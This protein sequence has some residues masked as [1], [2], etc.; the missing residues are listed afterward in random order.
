MED[1]TPTG[2]TKRTNCHRRKTRCDIVDKGAP[3]TNCSK[4]SRPGCRLYEKKTRSYH[5]DVQPR[6]NRAIRPRDIN[7]VAA[8]ASGTPTRSPT[9]VAREASDPG[10][11]AEFIDRE[12][13]RT[14]AINLRG[15]MCFI[16]TG[17]SNFNYLVRQSSL[18]PIDEGAVHFANRQ[19]HPV[20]TAHDLRSVPPSALERLD[21][22]LERRLL[23]AYFERVNRGWPIVDEH[24]FMTQYES[25]DPEDGPSLP[26]LNAILIVGAHALGSEDE[27]LKA[28]QPVLFRRTK[29]LI[30]RRFDQDRTVYVQAALL[31]TWYSDGLE[32]LT[33]NAWH[34]IGIATRIALGHGIHRDVTKSRMLPVSKRIWTR[35]WWVLVQFDTMVSASYGRI[36]ALDID[37][38]DVPELERSHFEGIPDADAD[39]VIQHSKLCC[40][41]SRTMRRRWSLRST[42]QSQVKATREAD[43]ALALFVSQLPP[44]LHLSRPDMNAWKATLHLTY[45]NFLILLHRPAPRNNPT[46]VVSDAVSNVCSDL[47]VCGVAVVAMASIFDTLRHRGLL[48][49]LWLYDIHALFTA[50]IHVSCELKL[51]NPLVSARAQQTFESLMASLVVLARHWRFAQGLLC[52]FQQRVQ[53]SAPRRALMTATWRQPSAESARNDVQNV[54]LSLTPSDIPALQSAKGKVSGG[55]IMQVTG[56]HAHDQ[57][58]RHGDVNGT[59]A[60]SSWTVGDDGYIGRGVDFPTRTDENSNKASRDYLGYPHGAQYADGDGFLAELPSPDG[61]AL[62]FLLGDLGGSDQWF[63]L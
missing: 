20:H 12:E 21:T 8:G 42:V 36:P 63:G 46:N 33:A 11:L 55:N 58:V 56:I 32:E 45:N 7:P 2:R 5:R 47:S 23:G 38:S 18:N 49:R 25:K 26:L 29:T 3:C 40:I 14:A 62:D 50:M 39:F 19:F 28:L 30:D 48:L 16:G 57:T 17:V 24:H 60:T 1:Q 59:P 44:A 4:H 10:N 54:T 35:L 37:E 41:I 34:W 27:S 6:V 51:L 53:W 15:R 31:L 52:L 43:E 22:A 13:L 9:P 61:S